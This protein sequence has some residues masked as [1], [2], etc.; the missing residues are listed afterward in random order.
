M[1]REF[2]WPFLRA[3]FLAVLFKCRVNPTRSVREV[4]SVWWFVLR[5]FTVNRWLRNMPSEQLVDARRTGC[6]NCP[7]YNHR[8]MTCGTPGK[9]FIDAATGKAEHLGCLCFM[10]VKS[11]LHVNCWL[12]L[13]TNG[14]EGWPDE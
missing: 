7:I 10:P 2:I 8:L 4:L 9:L 6:L 5:S 14:A 12:W 3:S 13:R 1:K 11:N